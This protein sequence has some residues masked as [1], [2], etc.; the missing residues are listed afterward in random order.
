MRVLKQTIA[1]LV[2]QEVD[3]AESIEVEGALVV[4]LQAGIFL[5]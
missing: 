5:P 4:T 2:Y 3:A 1:T